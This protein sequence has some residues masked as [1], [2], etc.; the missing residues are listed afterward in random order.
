MSAVLEIVLQFCVLSLLAFGGINA[1]LPEIHRIAVDNHHWMNDATFAHLFA[2]AQ[3]APGPNFL[4]VT[5]I[6]WHVAGL[7]GALAATFAICAPSSLLVFVFAH[8]WE[9]AS[10]SPRRHAI[11]LGVA[12]L[13]VGL[14]LA[15]GWLISLAANESWPAFA[16]TSVTVVIVLSGRIHP[17]W[18]IAAGATLGLA[19]MV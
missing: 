5:L 13:A 18:V 7:A 1:L 2:I 9:R 12:P 10:H 4:I 11:Q 14:V 6:G 17:L 19:G 16:L 8:F 3:A 15:S